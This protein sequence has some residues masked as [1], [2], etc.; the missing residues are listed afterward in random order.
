MA[1]ETQRDNLRNGGQLLV[2]GLLANGA[3]MAFC[4]PGESYLTALDALHDAPEIDLLTCRQEGGAAMMA[5]AYGKLTGRPGLCFVTRG[6]GAANAAGGVHVA[7]Q[8]STPMI[9]FVG[10]VGRGMRDREAFQEIDY[11]RM[12]GQMAKWVAEI[13]SAERVPEYINRAYHTAMAGR[14]GPVVLALPEDMQDD[15]APAIP[16]N[17]AHRIQ[18]SPSSEAMTELRQRLEKAERPLVVLGGNFWSAKGIANIKSFA[19]AN[20]LPISAAF[21]YQHLFNNEHPNYAGDVGIGINPKLAD[22]VKNADLL[23]AAGP[24]LGE[25]TTGGYSLLDIPM[26]KQDLV[27]VYPGAEE[28]GRVYRP[29]LA[30][31]AGMD[32]FAQAIAAM[33]PVH[34][35]WAEDTKQAHADY[36]SWSEPTVVPGDV[37]VGQVVHMLRDAM[38]DDGVI[39]NGAGNFAAFVHRFFRYRDFG[40]Q[41]APTSGSMGYGVP[42]GIAAKRMYPNRTVVTVAGDGDFMMT[43]QELATAAHHGINLIIVIVNNGMFGTIRMHQE[44]HFPGRVIATELS[45][46]DFQ[47]LA[48]AYGAHAEL[49]TNTVD[50]P[51]AFSRAQESGKPAI[52]E[53]TVDPEAITPTATLSGLR[54]AAEGA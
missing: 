37:N 25:M 51:E 1:T 5:D 16:L 39:T 23:I 24:R 3:D 40:T 30:I 28:L 31:N 34:G 35:P 9:L 45:N 42:A 43:G 53:L 6:P 54:K 13:D 29:T 2:D 32:A 52:I 38:P 49:V 11:R 26:P 14:P 44:K 22:R 7:F 41:L 48:K 36:L 46:P 27:H 4:V 21:R 47:V 19:E 50:F 17:T 12:F 20:H 15:R 8:D 10:Q 33:E 18:P